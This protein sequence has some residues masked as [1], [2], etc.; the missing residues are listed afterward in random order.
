MPEATTLA[1]KRDE[2]KESTR[3]QRPV[4]WDAADLQKRFRDG[5]EGTKPREWFT[6]CTTQSGTVRLT[7]SIDGETVLDEDVADLTVAKERL[8]L[9]RTCVYVLDVPENPEQ[10]GVIE[11]V[12]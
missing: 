5:E 11:G 7:L 6:A 1:R 4:K 12:G 8:G 10:S 3:R 2:S 9:L